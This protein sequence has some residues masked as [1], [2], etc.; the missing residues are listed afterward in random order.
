MLQDIQKREHGAIVAKNCWSLSRRAILMMGT[1]C[2]A[3]RVSAF[4]IYPDDATEVMAWRCSLP[5][6]PSKCKKPM[7]RGIR[8]SASK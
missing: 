6:Q 2:I 1:S 4:A 7:G 5:M 3:A 8:F